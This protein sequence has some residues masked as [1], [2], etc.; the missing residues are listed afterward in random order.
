MRRLLFSAV[1]ATTIGLFAAPAAS[2]QQSFN[3]YVGAFVPHGDQFGDGTITGRTP[4]DVL[5]NNADFLAFNLHDFHNVTFGGEWL[6]ALTDHIDAGLGVGYYQ[7]TVPSVYLNFVNENG[8]EIDQDLR[9]RIVPFSATIRLLPL[10]HHDAFQPYVGA[11]VGVLAWNYRENGQFIDS[12]NNI[13]RGTFTGSGATVGPLVFGGARFPI[14]SV[15]IGGEIRYQ[16][17]SGDLPASQSFAGS[18][19]DLGGFN[20]LFTMNF[21]F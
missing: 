18:K 19:I 14:G 3:F 11:G 7:R 16:S 8:S 6:F 2:A 4:D 13:F 15:D 5:T 1:F 12:G 10:G 17:G 21:R 9:L 20:Y